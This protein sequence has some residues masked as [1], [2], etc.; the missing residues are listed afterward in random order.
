MHHPSSTTIDASGN[1]W[2]TNPSSNSI[3]VLASTGAPLPGSPFTGN[4]LNGP[5][6]LAIDTS[7]NAWV[8]NTGGASISAFTPSGAALTGSPFTAASTL[9]APGTLAFDAPGNLWIANTSTSL[10]ELSPAGNF[11]QQLPRTVSG[12]ATIAINPR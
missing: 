11:L 8:A 7:G 1:V 6:A 12:P 5:T 3:T 10:V 9:S 2:I 4:G